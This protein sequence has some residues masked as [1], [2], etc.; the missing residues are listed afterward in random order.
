[1]LFKI[2]LFAPL[3]IRLKTYFMQAKREKTTKEK[4]TPFIKSNNDVF[5]L[6][7]IDKR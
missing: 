3:V 5:K 7:K 2:Q 1:M 6:N 4:A